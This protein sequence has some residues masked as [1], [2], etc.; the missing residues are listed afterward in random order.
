[1]GA[2]SSKESNPL[3]LQDNSHLRKFH[4]SNL[5]NQ[6][7]GSNAPVPGLVLESNT[8]PGTA[9]GTLPAETRSVNIFAVGQGG[10]GGS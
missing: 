3:S 1:M 7:G 8:Y 5:S 9:S 6:R 2:R 4:R 10:S